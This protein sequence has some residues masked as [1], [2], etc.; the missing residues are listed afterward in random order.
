MCIRD[1]YLEEAFEGRIST[2]V[3][4]GAD[5]E[6]DI[7]RAIEKLVQAGCTMIFTTNSKMVNQSVRSA[8]LH[9]EVKIYNCSCLLYTSCL[10]V[11]LLRTEG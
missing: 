3:I 4:E 7:A 5:T 1:R 10:A 6:G 8:I 9:P 11:F 2:V